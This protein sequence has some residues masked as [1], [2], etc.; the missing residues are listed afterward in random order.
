MQR[1][2]SELAV[3]IGKGEMLRDFEWLKEV[4]GYDQFCL[5][6]SPGAMGE[7]EGEL[8]EAARNH[9]N[10][11]LAYLRVI[12][13]LDEHPE[14]FHNKLGDFRLFAWFTDPDLRS[15][16]IHRIDPNVEVVHSLFRDIAADLG[17]RLYYAGSLDERDQSGHFFNDWHGWDTWQSL[18]SHWRLLV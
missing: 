13:E 5:F 4:Q 14:L 18:P 16:Q 2:D 10:P 1:Y 17:V 8:I 7:A 12:H 6:A 15:L 9:E 3:C 11:E